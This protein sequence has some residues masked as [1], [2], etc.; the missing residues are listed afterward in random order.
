MNIL[1]RMTVFAAA[2]ILA[3]PVSAHHSDAGMDMESTITFDG[4]V[5]EFAWR[6]P[7]VYVIVETEQSGEPVDWELQMGPVHTST[8]RGWTRDSLSP[9]DQV[10]V[11]AN[12]MT[13]GRPYGILRS[14]DKE[15]L[16]MSQGL[17][18]LIAGLAAEGET[19][20]ATSLAG[21]WLTDLSK[22]SRYPGGFDGFFHANLTLNDKGRAWASRSQRTFR[23]RPLHRLV[24]GRYAGGGH[25]ELCGSPLSIPDRRAV[26]WTEAR[27]RAI[28]PGGRR[29]LYGCRIHSGGP[30]V[31]GEAH[32]AL[33]A[34]DSRPASRNDIRGV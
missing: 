10:R 21:K 19:P 28:P 24:A 29:H 25:G 32:A 34:V 12:P 3:A 1:R 2:L 30:R 15:G 13:D 4:T 16:S 33:Q 8:R 6:N 23:H 22:I 11:Q 26:G 18:G 27:D 14:L 7:H 17:P 31:S 20:P 9:G 5:K